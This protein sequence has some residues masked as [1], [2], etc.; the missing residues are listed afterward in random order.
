MEKKDFKN[1][2]LL[3]SGNVV[4]TF[5]NIVLSNSLNLWIIQSSGNVKTLGFISS[6]SLLPTLVFTIFG[7]VISDS[8]NKKNIVIFCD[9]SSFMLCL[10][11]FFLLN[12]SYI[13][14]I[15]I[16]LFR[17]CLSI[18]H[19]LFSP[20][21]RSM[22]AYSISKDNRLKFNSYFSMSSNIVQIISPVFSGILI[23]LG[24]SIKNVLLLDAITFLLSAM[25]EVFI[26]Y[27]THINTKKHDKLKFLDKIYSSFKYISNDSYL[28]CII[29]LASIVNIFIAGYN[30]FLPYYSNLMGKS[31]YG[32]LLATEAIGGV[33]G[34]FTLQFHLFRINKNIELNLFISMIC[35]NLFFITNNIYVLYIVV[36]IFGVFLNRFN[37][38][39]FTY[40]QNKVSKK[41]IGRIISVT[42]VL[43]LIL[44]PV[45]QLIFSIL[46]DALGMITFALIGLFMCLF[47]VVYF[48]TLK[49][50][51]IADESITL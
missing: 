18:I 23:G 48:I 50:L 40:L 31:Y 32:Y 25:S 17:V 30:L 2:L 33:V 15:F 51:K 22:P 19:S 11:M 46:I 37:I 7:G 38:M 28:T 26:D 16:V 27:D 21:I 3:I 10:I 4:T 24:L 5:G 14:I 41:F 39:F 8:F 20:T 6:I 45:G 43:A 49:K 34:A 1:S 29:I 47:Y 9:L 12:E 36:F 42:T 44:M 13:N 35:F